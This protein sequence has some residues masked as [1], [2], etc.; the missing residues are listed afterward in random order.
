MDRGIE[1]TKGKKIG[2][3]TNETKRHKSIIPR[4]QKSTS[5]VPKYVQNEHLAGE[6][7]TWGIVLEANGA[8]D[9]PGLVLVASWEST[10][11]PKVA[12]RI[13]LLGPSEHFG[14]DLEVFGGQKV[15]KSDLKPIPKTKRFVDFDFF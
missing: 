11:G 15:R 8:Q 13:Q 3:S 7:S 1:G 10:W 5:G 12:K 9:R 14:P 6:M 2:W 4:A